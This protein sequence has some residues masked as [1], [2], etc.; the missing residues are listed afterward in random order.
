MNLTLGCTVTAELIG[1]SSLLLRHSQRELNLF[2]FTGGASSSSSSPFGK[3]LGHTCFLIE[4]IQ[5]LLL[6]FRNGLGWFRNCCHARYSSQSAKQL[7]FGILRMAN[8]C[9]RCLFFCHLASQVTKCSCAKAL[10]SL[11]HVVIGNEPLAAKVAA[12]AE[13]S[14]HCP[15][16]AG[17]LLS[18]PPCADSN[19][20][21]GRA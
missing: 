14:I 11:R 5:E 2:F 16:V 12:A 13:R 4:K 8:A 21:A 1:G 6:W 18:H 9:F 3:L 7:E 10:D 19:L 17:K 20:P 15:E